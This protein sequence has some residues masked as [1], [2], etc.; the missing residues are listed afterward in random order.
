M[1]DLRLPPHPSQVIDRSRR[2]TFWFDGR[3]IP[4]Y[5]GD[6]IASAL[7]ASGVRIFNRSFKYHRPRGLLCVS[8]RCPNCMMNVD[9]VPNVR[10]CIR[11]ATEG[12]QVR[13]QNAWPSLEHDVLSALERF[14]RLMP[15][16]F[17]Y[18][19]LFRPKAMW[20]LSEPIMRRVAGLGTVNT[21]HVPKGE[22]EHRH[23]FTDVAVVGG[24][25]AGCAAAIEAAKQGLRVTLIDDQPSLG[26]HFRWETRAPVNS[27]EYSGQAGYKVAHRLAEAA[28]S[29]PNINILS[30]ATAF[31]LYEGKLLG[32]HQDRE[33][34]KLRCRRIV[35]A[36]GAHEVPLVFPNNDLPGIMLSSAAQKLVN[37]YGVKPGRQGLVVTNNDQGLVA[38]LELV[39][40][41]VEVLTV[42]D[43]RHSSRHDST[44][45]KA[46]RSKGVA[47][48]AP[49]TI[50][51]A[52]GRKQIEAAVIGRFEE[53]WFTGDEERIPCDFLCLAPGFDPASALLSQGDCQLI[54][55]PALGETVP[56]ELAPD[57]YAAGDVTGVHDAKVALLQG[58][59]AGLE[60]AVSLNE[61]PDAQLA[62]EISTLK[63]QLEDA[64]KEYR[65]SLSANPLT[66]IP[67]PS[68]KKFV[69]ICEDVTEKDLHDAMRE[70]FDDVQT[71]KRYSTVSM[72]PCQGKMCL[73]AYVGICAEDTG[74]SIEETGSTTPRPPIQPVPMGALAGPEHMP[75]RYTSIH[76]KHIE[77]G[78][79]MVEVG[80]WK[81]PHSYGSPLE[82]AMAVRAR[83]GIIDVTTLGKLDVRGK[84]AP[85]LMDKVYTHHFSNL[86]VGRVRYGII[87][88]DSG[89]ILDDGTVS[90]LAEDQYYLTTGTGNIDLVEEWF[91]WWLAGTGMCA[92]VTNITPGVAAIN[93]AGPRARETM[94][95]LTDIDLSPETFKYMRSA[96]GIVAGV[97]SLLMR[98]GF[99][100][101]TGWEIHF[102]A[103][104][105]EYIWDA[106]LEAG[107]EFGIS[108]FG[109]EAQRI[110]RLEK[111]HLIPGQ[112]TDVVSNPLE[113]DMGWAVKFDKEDFIGRSALKAVQERGLRNKLVGFVMENGAVPQ[114]GV[115]V[116]LDDHPVGK[117][118]SSRYSPTLG[119]GF[120]LA[121]VPAH[122]AEE[123]KEIQIRVN[124]QSTPARVT[125]EPVYDPEGKRLR[126]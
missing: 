87:C 122:L 26:G 68:K 18:K 36:T 5:E 97:P 115:P 40:A 126:E 116:L 83:V 50:R 89:I 10:T 64:Q 101:E 80:E 113:A 109:V 16:G 103:E 102:P 90:R 8:G 9:G 91:R 120:G 43:S 94:L 2:T 60:A 42:A 15:V 46:L 82:E 45:A 29:T 88:S 23:L 73:K 108:P 71:L 119:R 96:S 32:V 99:V 106:L 13:H 81:R 112:D 107:K 44:L 92:H 4:G 17:Y 76:H 84:D 72:G 48:L 78:G 75:F 41:G 74:R 33:L 34:V 63:G 59:L 100:G 70:G 49:Y 66:T 86:G 54:Y 62:E 121:W 118:T 38:A 111:K 61:S 98:I 21:D 55:D 57:I 114:D 6:T 104:Y 105:G 47:V 14:D 28:G 19:S 77:M 22:Y 69:C 52:E 53:G 95:K 125:M 12:A 39:E 110:L 7:Y 51:Q 85:V 58:R 93:L 27:G 123:G 30:G 3:R 67:V 31:G 65:V 1:T 35:V 117:V 20:H 37:L 25:P 11:P 24:G 56:S 124:G 79:H